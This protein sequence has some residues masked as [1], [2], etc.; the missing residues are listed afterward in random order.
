[1]TS[2]AW[3]RWLRAQFLARAPRAFARWCTLD[4]RELGE[5]GEEIAARY[6]RRRGC[7]IL[8]RRLETAFVEVDIVALDRRSIV[9]VEVKTGRIE[10]LPRPRA[11]HEADSR[12][13]LRRPPF[14]HGEFTRGELRWR[15]GRRCDA[16]RIAR[17]RRAARWLQ[18]QW[19]LGRADRATTRDRATATRSFH[20]AATSL[21]PSDDAA[22][23]NV[24]ADR[25]RV[26]LVE[27]LLP[28]ATRRPRV[29]HHADVRRPLA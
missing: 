9:C 23:P 6:L 1:M 27:V 12:R 15:P 22:A 11:S 20:L 3:S 26:D 29:L 4:D 16:A 19:D 10:P 14:A 8:G 17:L 7:R 5:W 13:A 28:T 25:A 2:G 18:A 21:A 24:R